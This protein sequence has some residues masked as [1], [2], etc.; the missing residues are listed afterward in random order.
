[1]E[2]S[3]TFEDENRPV[4]GCAH[5]CRIDEFH[6]SSL[7]QLSPLLQLV[8]S[9]VSM[10]RDGL[11]SAMEELGERGDEESRERSGTSVKENV[12][13]ELSSNHQR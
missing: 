6:N 2:I 7:A 11:D 8:L 3:I 4:L 10:Q 13:A 12:L 1:M 9:D 5:R